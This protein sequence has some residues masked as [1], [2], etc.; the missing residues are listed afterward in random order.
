MGRF[1]NGSRPGVGQGRH[2]RETPGIQGF[3]R[4]VGGSVFC[5]ASLTMVGGKS[6]VGSGTPQAELSFCGR[7]E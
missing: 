5:N 1:K 4:G 2:A 6:L 7:T 3:G